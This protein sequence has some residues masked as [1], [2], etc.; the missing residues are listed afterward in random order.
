[1][2]NL[3]TSKSGLSAQHTQECVADNLTMQVTTRGRISV[4]LLRKK[5]KKK[6]KQTS[7][8]NKVLIQ[9]KKKSNPIENWAKGTHKYFPE[10]ELQ[11]S[12]NT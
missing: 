7:L 12:A 3:T 4:A 6:K 8:V 1:M 2:I 9:F 10:R 5:K 11:R